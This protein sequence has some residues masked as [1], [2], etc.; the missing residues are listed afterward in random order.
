MAK[1]G[2][3]EETKQLKS[4]GSKTSEASSTTTAK[5]RVLRMASKREMHP[6]M[7]PW[8]L[9]QHQQHQPALQH[10]QHVR[11]YGKSRNLQ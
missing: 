8:Q 7:V 6:T 10:L 2:T 4:S 5:G 1:Q 3:V 9:E 11:K